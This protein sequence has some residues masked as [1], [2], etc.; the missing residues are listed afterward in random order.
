MGAIRIAPDLCSVNQVASLAGLFRKGRPMNGLCGM[1]CASS[2]TSERRIPLQRENLSVKG[3]N[4]NLIGPIHLQ[5][6]Q[7]LP[8]NRD[9]HAEVFGSGEELGNPNHLQGGE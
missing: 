3:Y 1:I 9:S 5:N 6:K 7:E 2:L 8:G 4:I